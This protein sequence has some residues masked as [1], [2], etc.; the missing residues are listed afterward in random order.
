MKNNFLCKWLDFMDLNCNE[1][2]EICMIK[3]KKNCC[4]CSCCGEC[5]DCDYF[6]SDVNYK[7]NMCKD[8][9]FYN[10]KGGC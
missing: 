5:G 6:L 4:E 9:C 7:T 10:K 2:V 1:S 8:C 3:K